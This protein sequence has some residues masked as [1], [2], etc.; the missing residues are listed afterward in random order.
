MTS[1]PALTA[2]VP[3]KASSPRSV[4]VP[5]PSLTTETSEVPFVTVESAL[6]V[7]VPSS[8]IAQGDAAIEETPF[9]ENGQKP[10]V[11]RRPSPARTSGRSVA[12]SAFVTEARPMHSSVASPFV[13]PPRTNA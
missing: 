5:D 9:R 2:S 6:S 11:L 10:L 13:P 12:A 7:F 1:V 4:H 3:E 8:V